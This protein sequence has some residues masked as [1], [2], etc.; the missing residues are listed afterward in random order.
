[1]SDQRAYS[2]DAF[3]R[4]PFR[5]QLDALYG[6]SARDR[7]DL[8]LSAPNAQ[9]LVRSFAAESLFHT[10]KEVGLEDGAELLALASGEQV[11]ALVDLDC[12]KKDRLET[13]LLLDWLEV[14]V[15]AGSRAVGELLNTIDRDLLVLLL[16]RF[17]RVHR[18]DDPEE[19]DE[20]V[21][22]PEVFEL[23]EHY[24]IV[25]H[26][27]DTRSPL[28]R[29]LIEELYERDYSYFV[30]VMEETWWG[31]ES[32]LEEGA[33]RLR[34][35]RLQ[36]RGFP[37]YFHA[38]QIYRPMR[39]ADLAERSSPLGRSNGADDAALPQD[40]SLVMPEDGKTF[41]SQ[42]LHAGF[43]GE[44]ASELRHELAY[45]VNRVLV[46][47]GVD[48]ADHEQVA[49]KIRVAHD[50]VNLALESLSE[51]DSA[52]A[53]RILE[54]H[55]V[56]HIFQVGWQILLELRKAAKQTVETLGL[57]ASAAGLAFL[58]T[59][60]R[61]A[62]GGLLRMKPQ[63]FAGIEQ[64]GEIRYRAFATVNDLSRA[65]SVL[66]DVA[67]LSDLCGRLLGQSPAE[68]ASLRPRDADDF[69]ISAVILTALAHVALGHP[70][71]LEPLGEAELAALRSVARDPHT[72]RLHAALRDRLRELHPGHDGYLD[73][74]LRRLEEEFLAVSADRPL[75][76]RFVTCLMIRPA[77]RG[78]EPSP[79]A[80]RP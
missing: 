76:P 79:H 44:A 47:E 66:H 19:P 54:R 36:D 48:F 59:P 49:Q 51:V 80:A 6:V 34:S 74:S 3:N 10:L 23:D 71:S 70:P 68:L 65:R 22:G 18:R 60:Y 17:I 39:A 64:A 38:Q 41:F 26:R 77:K 27:S 1:M 56:Q 12:W 7:R 73:F 67:S 78:G 16:K 55:Y 52:H 8:I 43:S 20:D 37:D 40:R 42:V 63:F 35:A 25:F 28:V 14:I 45:L 11:C 50:T 46:A 15:E 32:D 53:I 57:Q 29:S 21:E 62:L 58:D 5:E 13:A 72:G 75:D 69:R 9:R 31:V 24:Q 33:F 2:S 4:L 61:E 30:T